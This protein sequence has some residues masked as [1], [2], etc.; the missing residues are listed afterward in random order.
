M[1]PVH[2][3]ITCHL[4]DGTYVEGISFRLDEDRPTLEGISLKP[5]IAWISVTASD[6]ETA[7]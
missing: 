7:S 2:L 1:T 4:A 6:V 3:K 5:G